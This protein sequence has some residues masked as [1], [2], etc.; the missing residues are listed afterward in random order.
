MP[1]C[2]KRSLD[3]NNLPRETTRRTSWPHP[4]NQEAPRKQGHFPLDTQ[5]IWYRDHKLRCTAR[6]QTH[7]P[8]TTTSHYGQ[9]TLKKT[10]YVWI[11]DDVWGQQSWILAKFFFVRVF[12][13]R[14]LDRDRVEVHKL[15]K[16]RT[17]TISSHLDQ[18]NLVNKRFS[19]WLS[20]KFFLRD[21]TGGPEL[22]R[23]LHLDRSSNQSQC[24][25]LF[26]LPAR[27]AG[28]TMKSHI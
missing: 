19:I 14:F 22:A 4:S 3:I 17:R 13:C 9:W 7:H 10:T 27:R 26:I 8:S 6:A 11:I 5:A 21:E 16:K 28:H 1:S 24:R 15:A 12:A 25:I 20:G 18:T 2:E 23:W